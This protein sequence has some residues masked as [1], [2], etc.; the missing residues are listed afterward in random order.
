MNDIKMS[1][2]SCLVSRNFHS[3]NYNA[4]NSQSGVFPELSLSY[5]LTVHQI[6]GFNS[7]PKHKRQSKRLLADTGLPDFSMIPISLKASHPS[8]ILFFYQGRLSG[9]ASVISAHISKRKDQQAL[10]CLD[11][12]FI[13]LGSLIAVGTRFSAL[14]P[15]K[16]QS[17]ASK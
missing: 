4:T 3:A 6:V 2:V 12:L 7:D 9:P 14:R 17:S 11:L 13:T 1:S 10:L 5:L 16:Y 8:A 15:N